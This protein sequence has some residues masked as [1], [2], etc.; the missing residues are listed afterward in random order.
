[1]ITTRA[2][3]LADQVDRTFIRSTWA[4]AFKQSN[5]AGLIYTDDWA[6]VMHRQFDRIL[7]RPGARA[8]IACERNDPAFFYGWIAGDT[9]GPSPVVFF[10]YVKEP[11]RRRGLGRALLLELGVGPQ[12][13]FT[14]VCRTP[15]TL[16]LKPLIPL[17]RFNPQIVRYP[18]DPTR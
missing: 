10:T 15:L 18:K 12:T 13:P 17:G 2:A 14:F 5:D 8:I 16:H 9:T 11:Y 6:E 7:D 4:R 3:K 1:M